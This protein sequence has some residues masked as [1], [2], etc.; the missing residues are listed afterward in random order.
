MR[1]LSGILGAIV[2]AG[3][4]A[5]GASLAGTGA[6]SGARIDA[7]LDAMT[8]EEKLGQ[9]S[10][11]SSGWT[12]TGPTLSES[13]EA[14]L[15]AGR[16][17]AIFNAH[18][19][20]ATRAL[21][22]IAVEETRLGIPLLFGYDVIHGY[23][24][25]FPTP[26]AESSS[27][28]L[29]VVRESARLAA[30]EAAAAGLNWTFAPMVD[31]AR[32]PRWGRVAEGAGEDPYL[33]S[34]VAQARV[35]GFQGEDLSDPFTV[36]AC[37]KHY[38]GYGAA[39]A[40]RD[41]H[42][43]DMS[44][45]MLREV[46]LPPF[47]AAVS[48]GVSS[49]MTGFNDLNGVPA[50]ANAQLIEEVLREEWGF[51][52]LVVSD[53]TSINELVAH[54]VAGDLSEAAAL[55]LNSGVDLDLQGGVYSAFGAALVRTGKVSESRVDAA[56]RRVLEAK[57]VLGLL[58]DPYRYLDPRREQATVLSE[59]LLQHAFEAGKR[60]VVLLKNA[61]VDGKP[62]LPLSKE[63]RS[64]AVVGPMADARIDV[65]GTWHA[66]GALGIDKVVT[67]LEGVRQMLPS[68]QVLHARGADFS[69][70]DRSGFAAAVAAAEQSELVILALGEAEAQSGEAASRANIGLPGVQQRLAQTIQATGK[71]LVVLIGAGRPLATEWISQNVPAIVNT[72][73]LGTM[74][75]KAVA[76]VLFGDYNPSGKLTVTVPR[77]VGQI[78]I[79]Y[80]AKTTGRP[81]AAGNKYSSKYLDVSNEPLYPFGHGLSY[82]TFEYADLRLSQAELGAQERLEISVTVRNSGERAGEEVV[83]LY[84]RDRVA[85]L[86]RPVKELKGFRKIRLAAGE[87]QVV[88]F[89]LDARDLRFYDRQLRPVVEPGEFEVYVGG[90]S[91][92]LVQSSF[93]L[94]PADSARGPREGAISV[95]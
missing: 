37:A 18:T 49:I 82:T 41:Y 67:V 92:D 77:S 22:R 25:I 12:T 15:R 39:Q 93:R 16:V 35:Q 50:T 4:W 89:E 62:L 36:L 95:D 23:Q 59:A 43:V 42:S 2:V 61:P 60:S 73:Q 10:V 51:G 68:A 21:Q 20:G 80:S 1:K 38:A 58:D 56:V 11:Y 53:Y 26:L 32:D 55:A 52:G 29:D 72:W 3:W 84:L 70:H 71:P 30:R 91:E 75:G 78:P 76:A 88:S 14:E 13:Y 74:H 85:S 24:T 33:A 17:G 46:Y 27:W 57:L 63:L 8:L 65:L 40:G 90:N 31:I 5:A 47:H 79:Y 45:R 81:H 83:Q 69:G 6:S 34:L 44:E 7:L 64:V 94:L 54:G 28:D 9:L 48:A 66:A 19:V 87:S 86:T